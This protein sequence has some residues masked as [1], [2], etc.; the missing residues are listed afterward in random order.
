M[1][2]SQKAAA[3]EFILSEEVFCLSVHYG[4]KPYAW[5]TEGLANSAEASAVLDYVASNPTKRF[6]VTSPFTSQCRTVAKAAAERNLDNVRVVVPEKVGHRRIQPPAQLLVT[7][8]ATD[9]IT[10]TAWPLSDLG[11]LAPLFVGDWAGITVFCSPIVAEHHPVIRHL[12]GQAER[13]P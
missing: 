2:F 11:R 8:A 4:R 3:A 9:P 7:M 13:S 12:E 1:R 5:L 6:V 10:T